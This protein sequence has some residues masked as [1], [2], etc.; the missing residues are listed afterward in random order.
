MNLFNKDSLKKERH[1]NI[2]EIRDSEHLL[3]RELPSLNEHFIETD[4]FENLTKVMDK[5]S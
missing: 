2:L 5:A 4:I 3:N 1:Q